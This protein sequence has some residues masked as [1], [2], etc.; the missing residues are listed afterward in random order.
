M[1]KKFLIRIRY[2]GYGEQFDSYHGNNDSIYYG[3]EVPK[4]F[5]RRYGMNV[6]DSETFKRFDSIVKNMIQRK[7]NYRVSCDIVDFDL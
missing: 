4:E 1:A 2:D 7:S 5:I 6:V 3:S